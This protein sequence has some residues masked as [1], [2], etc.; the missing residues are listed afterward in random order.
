MAKRQRLCPEVTDPELRGFLDMLPDIRAFNT[1]LVM[2]Q[3]RTAETTGAALCW[4]TRK[5]Q[6]SGC[7]FIGLYVIIRN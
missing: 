2:G 7:F 5:K 1:A 6:P 4:E 3:K